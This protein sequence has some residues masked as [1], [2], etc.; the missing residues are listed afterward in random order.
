M[1]PKDFIHPGRIKV[2]LYDDLGTTTHPKITSSKYLT[3]LD[4]NLEKLLFECICDLLPKHKIR[5][6]APPKDVIEK[7]RA[8][9]LA[10][11]KKERL[12]RQKDFNK[13][14]IRTTKKNRTAAA[15]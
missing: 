10:S 13:R 14:G 5:L 6:E 8:E 3:H 4:K 15:K 7:K 2:Q 9:V 12:E 11:F 1:H